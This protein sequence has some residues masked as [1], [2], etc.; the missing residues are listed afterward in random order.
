MNAILNF[1]ASKDKFILLAILFFGMNTFWV[2]A[3]DY[4]KVDATIQLYPQTFDSPEAL[5]KFILRDFKTEEEQVRGIY[6][7]IIQNIAYEPNEYKQFDYKFKNYRERNQKE[8]KTR[9]NV[10]NRTIQKGIAVCEGYAMLFERLCEL[11]GIQNYLVRGDTKTNFNDIGRSF[12]KN[13]MWN[14][15]YIDG[16]PNLFDLTWGAGKYHEKFIKEPTYFYY[17]TPSDLFFKTH[18]P[19]MIEDA[20]IVET[21]SRE[22]FS[23]RPLLIEENLTLADIETPKNGIINSMDFYDAILF[24]IKNLKANEISYSYGEKI[25]K[26]SRIDY[27]E[28]GIKFEIPLE[29]GA[30][31]L[32]IYFDDKPAIGYKVK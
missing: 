26:I 24:S 17:K 5:A 2:V 13:H 14:V 8:E 12:A 25:K 16:A 30:D 15:A 19:D 20:F 7:W 28:K 31:Q 18:Y 21:V 1:I 22:E 23:N 6:S 9:E 3:Q 27:T 4:E 29:L 10:I 11:L 32:L